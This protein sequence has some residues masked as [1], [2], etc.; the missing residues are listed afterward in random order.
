MSARQSPRR[1]A[2]EQDRL[3]AKAEA[4][5]QQADEIDREADELWRLFEEWASQ[6]RPGEGDDKVAA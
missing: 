1:I 2:V 6:W 4:L 3:R 5:R